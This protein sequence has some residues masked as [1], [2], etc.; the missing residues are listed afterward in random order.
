MSLNF[1][2]SIVED[3]AMNE[4]LLP[5]LISGELR[6]THPKILAEVMQ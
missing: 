3:A 4:T 5:K 2:E 6:V 1:T